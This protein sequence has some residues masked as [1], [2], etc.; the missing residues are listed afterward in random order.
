RI[1]TSRGDRADDLIENRAQLERIA[2][3]RPEFEAHAPSAGHLIL[4]DVLIEDRR[5]L[6]A[7]QHR[8]DA[9][10]DLARRDLL[11]LTAGEVDHETVDV[12]HP[13]VIVPG[14]DDLARRRPFRIVAVPPHRIV[15]REA[16]A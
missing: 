3:L 6:L 4:H 11:E 14:R 16:L 2:R 8:Y 15:E 7:V 12:F 9:A 13:P 5:R 1:R 10:Q